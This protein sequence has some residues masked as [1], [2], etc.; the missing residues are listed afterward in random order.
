MQKARNITIIIL[1]LIIIYFLFSQFN[2]QSLGNF[3]VY[4][5]NPCFFI[6]MALIIKFTI[7]STYKTKEFKK[8]ILFYVIV[9]AIAYGVVLLASGLFLTFGHNPYS[10]TFTGI[11]LNL[12]SM[13]LVMVCIEYIRYKLINNVYKK[14]KILILIL[15][16]VT[17]TLKDIPIKQ[18]INSPSIYY[19]FKV[20]F[21]IIIPSVVKNILFT[22]MAMYSDYKPAIVYQLIVYFI[23]WIPPILPNAPWIYNSVIDILFPL[24]LLLYCIYEISSRDKIHIYKYQNPIKPTGLIPLTSGV[25]LVI[26][27]AIGI[28]PIKPLGIASGSMEPKLHIG[29][30]VFI[31]KCNANDVKIDDIIEYQRNDFSVIHRVIDK[32]QKDGVTFFIT[33]G[34]NNSNKDSDPISEV[35]LKGKVIGRIPYLA[36]PT[37]WINN[38]GGRQVYVDVE[39]GK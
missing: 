8:N 15:I 28:F 33:K 17:F 30:L 36:M 21:T 6:I 11:L 2:L 31:K 37:I 18:I 35:Y 22:Y 13:G 20:L 39:T 14:D 19:I 4:I 5:I 24:V 9:T 16:V 25:V 3:Y 27:F 26:W 1:I 38:L 12:Y 10:N 29:D 34:D 23:Q 32:Y 7:L